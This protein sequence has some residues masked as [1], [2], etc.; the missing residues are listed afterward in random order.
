MNNIEGRFE[1]HELKN[2]TKDYSILR[3]LIF[4]KRENR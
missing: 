1:Y 4:L 2:T 3:F